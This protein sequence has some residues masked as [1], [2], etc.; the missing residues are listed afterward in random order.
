MKHQKTD[1]KL[2]AESINTQKS[3]KQGLLGHFETILRQFQSLAFVLFLAPIAL[4]YVFCIGA[5]V[6][7]AIY[8]FSLGHEM[9][10]NS[11]LVMQAFV[12]GI[13]LGFGFVGFVFVLIFVVPLCNWPFRHLVKSYRGPWFSLESIPWFYHNALTYLVRYTILNFITPTPLNILF[14]KMMGMKI[15]KG[16]MINTANISD[17]CMIELGDYVTIGGSAYLMAHYGMKG[18][19]IIDK[20]VVR[21]KA[22]VGLHAYLMGAVEVGEFAQVLP[23]T[24]VL[25]KT[26][27]PTGQKFG[28]SAKVE[29]EDIS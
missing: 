14:F 23:N 4:M 11:N 13:S 20:L 12:G 28:L 18:F 17:P 26:K 29:Q 21:S 15:G 9:F 1:E 5:A 24:A 27:I 8:L 7:P 10:K 25:P 6:T 2:S 19:L 22:N 3:K 16:T